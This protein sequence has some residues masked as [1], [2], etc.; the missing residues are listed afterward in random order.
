MTVELDVG[1]RGVKACRAGGSHPLIERRR[2]SERTNPRAS[3]KIL[4]SSNTV[5]G[6]K[7]HNQF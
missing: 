3:E 4:D 5:K 7:Y 6:G 2:K 1:G